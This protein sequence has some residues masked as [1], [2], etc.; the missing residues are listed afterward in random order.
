MS[1]LHQRPERTTSHRD[2]S[3]FMF[4]YLFG[5]RA[6]AI[7]IIAKEVMLPRGLKELGPITLDQSGP[8]VRETLMLYTDPA[9][10]PSVVHCTQGKDR[11]GLICIMLL[12]I[13]DI[14]KPAIE[15]DYFLTDAALEFQR[16]K[17]VKEMAAIGLPPDWA[18]TTKEMIVSLEKHLDE[19]YGG[20]D[21]Y[22][23]GIGF[24]KD[25]RQRVRDTLMY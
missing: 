2:R 17:R 18:L 4:L 11:T 12:M 1:N 10:L 5:Y 14:P 7:G 22:L 23:D 16:E 13:L 25:E 20:L 9:Q 15:H 6:E 3:K 24:G 21:A 19:K 8:L